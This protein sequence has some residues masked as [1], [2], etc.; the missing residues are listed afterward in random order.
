MQR[1]ITCFKSGLMKD[2]FNDESDSLRNIATGVV[3]PTNVAQQ[4]VTSVEKGH[5]QMIYFIQQHFNS[6]NASFWDAIPNLKIHTFSSTMKKT[7]MKGTDEKLVVITEDRDLFGRLLI[8]TNVW[9]VNLREI[10]SYDHLAVPYSLVHTDGTLRKT[11]KSVLQ[12]L[13]SKITVEPWMRSLPT[14]PTA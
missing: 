2:P 11:T 6:N 3:L 12:I 1:I 4:L 9:Q 7:K 13:E 8:I 14:V 5:E 10:L